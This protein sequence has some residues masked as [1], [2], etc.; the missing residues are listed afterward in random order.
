MNGNI[1][2][3]MSSL[4]NQT[5]PTTVE[6][7]IFTPLTLDISVEE[8]TEAVNLQQDGTSP[9]LDQVP[10]SLIKK[11][12]PIILPHMLLSFNYVLNGFA[13]FSPS[14][15]TAKIIPKNNNCDQI[16]NWRPSHSLT[17][18]TNCIVKFCLDA[19]LKYFQIC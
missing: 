7:N 2:S 15:K 1:N 6:E 3:F 17:V 13:D 18:S 14:T 8:L 19:S 12:Y 11:I 9:G 4:N 16:N 10:P 5:L